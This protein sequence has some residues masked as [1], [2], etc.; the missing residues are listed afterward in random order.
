[1]THPKACRPS[2]CTRC[3]PARR[4]TRR[5]SFLPNATS[6]FSTSITTSPIKPRRTRSSKNSK[7]RN[8]KPFP[9]STSAT[10]PSRATTQNGT[11]NSWVSPTQPKPHPSPS[12]TERQCDGGEFLG[13]A[14]ASTLHSAQRLYN[15][16]ALA[17]D[18]LQRLQPFSKV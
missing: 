13:E 17:L 12:E 15:F 4:A 6:H 7:P 8:C 11:Q 18:V 10:R 1:M 5:R 2:R 16:W 9:S 3:R 14:G